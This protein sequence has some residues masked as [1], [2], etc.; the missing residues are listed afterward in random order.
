MKR[1]IVVLNSPACFSKG[2]TK[3]N[4]KCRGCTWLFDCLEKRAMKDKTLDNY[5]NLAKQVKTEEELNSFVKK[6]EHLSHNDNYKLY[7]MAYE[8]CYGHPAFDSEGN[9][10]KD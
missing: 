8:S 5:E 2:D 7:N 3:T 4:P 9:F 1:K 10:Y 6:I